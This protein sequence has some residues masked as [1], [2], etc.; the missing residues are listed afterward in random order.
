MRNQTFVKS[1]PQLAKMVD[2]DA[3]FAKRFKADPIEVLA[4]INSAQLPNTSVYRIV[5]SALAAAIIIALVG[6][7]AITL[8]LENAV[9]IPDILI[10]T[11]ASA[12]GALAGLLAP[13]PIDN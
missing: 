7:I 3:E 2:H 8:T 9:P 10:A 4:E 6:A 11:A 5:V 13:Q 1:I 12:V